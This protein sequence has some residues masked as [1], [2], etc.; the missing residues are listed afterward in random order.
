MKLFQQLLVAGTALSFIAPIA[1]QASD[2]FNIEGIDSCI[3]A[4]STQRF[5]SKTFV[6]QVNEDIAA[7][8]GRLDGLEALQNNLEAGSFSDTTTLDG[9]AIYPVW[10]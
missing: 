5:D 10:F 2:T 9:K 6:N 7:L 8:K 3:V 1:A 4:K